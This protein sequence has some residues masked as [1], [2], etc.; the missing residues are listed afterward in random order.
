VALF[1]RRLDPEELYATHAIPGDSTVVAAW[2]TGVVRPKDEV[3]LVRDI[4]EKVC[5]IGL[6]AKSQPTQRQIEWVTGSAQV[7][8]AMQ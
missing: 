6:R 5:G 8:E 3:V 4:D 2:R 7:S 1:T